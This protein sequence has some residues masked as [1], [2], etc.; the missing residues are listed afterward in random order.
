LHLGHAYS[1]ITVWGV[2]GRLG[3]T[4][5]LRIEDTDSSR[6]R[7]QHEAAIYEDLAWLGLHWPTPVLRQSEHYIDYDKVLKRLATEGLI[8]PC[9]CSRRQVVDAGGV[10]GA[11]GIIYPGT[12]RIRS[13]SDAKP[14]DALRL[15]LAKA[16]NRVASALTYRET[17]GSEQ[18]QINVVP[19]RLIEILGDPVLRRKD[20]GDPAYH[21]ACVHDDARQAITHVV[22]G[23]DLEALTP[24]HVLLQAL[25]GLPTPIYHHHRLITDGQGKRLAKI[26]K[27]KAL[28][29]YRAE[30]LSPVDIRQMIGFDS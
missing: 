25:L 23:M 6:V 2:A 21:L 24:L 1:A 4:A 11:D 17:G 12:C 29:R 15:D 14:G 3:G 18:K 5:L 27:S 28:G 22:R 10:P 8:Y 7:P 26:D 19:E 16:A 30:G 9:S 20:T 13:M